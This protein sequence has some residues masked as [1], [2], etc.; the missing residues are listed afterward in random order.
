ME[1]LPQFVEIKGADLGFS[2]ICEEFFRVSGISVENSRVSGI[3]LEHSR[4]S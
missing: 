4:V 1:Q 2:G 3:S